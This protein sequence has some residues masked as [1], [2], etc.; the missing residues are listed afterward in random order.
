MESGGGGIS[1]LSGG[2][3]VV[4]EQGGAP[5]GRKL[6]ANWSDIK[7]LPDLV[8]I[9][10]RA[11]DFVLLHPLMP[12]AASH[13]RRETTQVVQFL[14]WVRMDHPYGRAA[15]VP[16]GTPTR[17]F[18]FSARWAGGCSAWNRGPGQSSERAGEGGR[19]D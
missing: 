3:H 2:H 7:G 1:L 12:H 17:S 13:N 4:M 18:Q 10:G 6:H 14:Q 9:T 8:E 16:A 15:A 11:G 5:G 19:N